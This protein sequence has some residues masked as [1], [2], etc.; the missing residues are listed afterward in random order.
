VNR[1]KPIY[2]DYNATTPIDP[3]VAEAMRPFLYEQFGNPSSSHW[4]GAQTRK[5]VENA[6]SQVAGLL[7]CE[8]DEV[9]FTS[10]GSESNNYA[11]KGA[12]L[13]RRAQGD[14]I[15][16]SAVEHPAV[17]EVCRFLETRGFRVTYLPVDGTGLVDPSTLAKAIGPHTVLVTIIHSNNQVGTIQPIAEL[18]AVA[19][20]RGVPIHTD[21]AQSV[22]KIPARVDELGVDLLSVAGHKLYAPKGIGALFIRRGL[23]LEKQIHGA[24]H[25][26][27]L[28]A[29]TENVL[30]AVGLGK[31]CEIAT[32]DLERNAAHA[33]RMRD[34]L[35]QG[36][37][38]ELGELRLNGHAEQRLP[39]TLSLGF[40]GVEA[41]TLLSEVQ[42]VAASAG[43][44]CHS[45]SVELSPVLTAMSVPEEFAM[46]T[47]RFST[48]KATT[49]D[50]VD[51]AVETLAGAV[52]R[53]R[54]AEG[55]ESAVPADAV[56][57]SGEIKL[58]RFTHGLGCA[59]KLRPQALEQVLRDLPLPEDSA[60]L[61]GTGTADDAAVYRIDDK[62]AIVQTLDFFTP[63]VDDPYEFGA[64]AAANALSD[65]YAMGARPL[66]A[67]NIVG[68]PTNHL[69][70]EARKR[71]LKGAHD[72]AREAGVSIIG[73][74]SVD[75][76]EPKY[77]LAVSGT[78]DPERILTNATARPGD[79]IVLTKP[80]GTG[81]LATAMKRGLVEEPIIRRAV[82]VMR[83]LNR[84]AAETMDD[85]P[86]SACTDVTGFGLLGHL[87][88]MAGASGV[89]AELNAGAVPVLEEVRQL[90]AANVVPGGSL[91][92]LEF[93]SDVVRWPDEMT[94]AERIVL[95]D[96]QTSG[97][98]LIAL[99]AD[100]VAGLIDELRRRGV[101]EAAQIGTFTTR[102]EGRITVRSS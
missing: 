58:T 68:F 16:T 69:P 20:E 34:L 73:G 78:I 4:Y 26:Q 65:I 67:L 23:R 72:V 15:V 47:V 92:N 33:K 59:C 54:P 95:C 77:G 71:I 94:R 35:H 7:G 93:V 31:A 14:H 1:V 55:G 53:L 40:R 82:S 24:D 48:G 100:D 64:I 97:G 89:D 84:A 30:L 10:G 76:T 87:K 39:N 29:G 99:P 43:A 13:A 75:D 25:E 27:N 21:A 22:G 79:A 57:P 102:G 42:E 32:R 8:A 86:V 88:E 6:R 46:G 5:A 9:I 74:H 36:L 41:D 60:V 11:I 2:L 62:T 44:A 98:L 37:E 45:D 38:R 50:E 19:K 63:V 90:A 3:E 101:E 28:R 70:L 66:F 49:E 61:V 91:D 80:I 85:F 18:A 56:S 52:R 96:A 81:I 51:R 17:I 12:A 83:T